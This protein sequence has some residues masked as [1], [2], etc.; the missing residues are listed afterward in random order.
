MSAHV[1]ILNGQLGAGTVHDRIQTLVAA[2]L[3]QDVG[4]AE[5][6][7]TGVPEKTIDEVERSVRPWYKKWWVWAIIVPVTGG[8]AYGG[9]RLATRNR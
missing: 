2:G 7:P 1:K 6:L 8:L 4:T 5:T 3:V 9:Y